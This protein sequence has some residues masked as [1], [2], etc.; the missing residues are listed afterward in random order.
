MM[1]D[2]VSKAKQILG[3][4]D[5]GQDDKQSDQPQTPSG[6]A[7]GY[8]PGSLLRGGER[9]REA[10]MTDYSRQIAQADP[11]QRTGMLQSMIE[12]EAKLDDQGQ[13]KMA[14][15]RLK[16]LLKLEP[17]EVESLAHTYREVIARIPGPLAFKSAAVA[18]TVGRQLPVEDYQR[19]GQLIPTVFGEN[20]RETSVSTPGPQEPVEPFAHD[21]YEQEKR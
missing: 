18:Q 19:L 9:E 4:D 2:I 15:S 12:S 10:W 20:P 17:N 14:L 7:G 16:S 8:D 21:R 13:E 6:S 1:E 5:K 11:G 3:Q